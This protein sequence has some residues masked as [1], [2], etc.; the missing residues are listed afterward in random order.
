MKYVILTAN[1]DALVNKRTELVNKRR[2]KNK[3]KLIN[4]KLKL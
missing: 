3:Y 4:V 1:D 2:H